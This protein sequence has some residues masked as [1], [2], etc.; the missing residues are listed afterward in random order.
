MPAKAACDE[1]PLK[2]RLGARIPAWIA[3]SLT[4]SSLVLL[5]G[6]MILPIAVVVVMSFTGYRLGDPVMEFTGIKNYTGLISDRTFWRSMIN[7]FY[8]VA[9]VVPGAVVLGLLMAVVVDRLKWGKGFY[10]LI[11]FLPV[12]ATAVA[13]AF[14]WRYLLHGNIGPFN[15]L[16]KSL[17]LP[18]VDFFSDPNLIF[19]V[20]I[21]ALTVPVQV[22][23]LPLFLGLNLAG[24]LDTYF[25]IMIPSFLSVFAIFLFR[26]TFKSYPD[27]IIQA[28]RMDGLSEW[29]ILWTIVVPGAI[30]AF[31]VFFHHHPLE[32]P[33]LAHGGDQVQRTHDPRLWGWPISPTARPGRT[34]VTVAWDGESGKK[35][36]DLVARIMKEGHMKQM[37]RDQTGQQFRRRP[38]R[39]HLP[40]HQQGP[41]LLRPDQGQVHPGLGRLPGHEPQE[42]QSARRRQR[43]RDHRP[44]PPKAGGR[45]GNTSSFASSPE[46]QK[47]AVLGSGYMP[48]NQLAM[49]PELL[50]DF[51]KE[52]PNWRTSL[53]QVDR[54]AAWDFYLGTNS[55]EIWR[56]QRNLI[57]RVMAG[58]LSVKDGLAK[59]V[60][61]TNGLIGK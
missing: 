23:A 26:Q 25:A 28:A 40:V 49:A 54:A 30:A 5:L 56:T 6:L 51:Y 60:K 46:G 59:M 2:R 41:R 45:L 43:R 47:L 53:D 55:V 3:Y 52:H 19:T 29:S 18:A 1:P 34:T 13:M 7:T 38:V 37:D 12:T 20:V 17:G 16:L 27:E 58:E 9:M 21:F 39:L 50:G 57:A 33:V 15:L 44:G 22:V 36:V 11:F 14:V 24:V 10:R 4:G 31:S 35:A 42:R 48:T 8:Y 32:R 61:E